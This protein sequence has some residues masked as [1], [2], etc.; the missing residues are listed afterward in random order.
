MQTQTINTV[1]PLTE[2]TETT[3]IHDSVTP[4]ALAR[5]VWPMFIDAYDKADVSEPVVQTVA[6]A[7]GL[8]AKRVFDSTVA[9]DERIDE[10]VQN[11]NDALEA[12]LTGN[13]HIIAM[14][15]LGD[16]L[17]EYLA[18]GTYIVDD[19]LSFI[20]DV[21]TE[22]ENQD[23][24]V[25]SDD[26]LLALGIRLGRLAGKPARSR[27]YMARTYFAKLLVNPEQLAAA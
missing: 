14:N 24:E 11:T 5:A 9:L 2:V 6:V 3:N 15:I 7:V 27:D 13:F 25:D 10:F 19:F 4:M 21:G 16:E 12:S 8:L 22:L 1:S 23:S 26:L 18:E 17:T 20:E